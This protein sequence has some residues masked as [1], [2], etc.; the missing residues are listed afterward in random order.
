MFVDRDVNTLVDVITFVAVRK[1][2][3]V[4]TW[5]EVSVFTVAV[6]VVEVCC[7]SSG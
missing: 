3:D 5:V 1:S 4:S 2:I 6:D 7:S